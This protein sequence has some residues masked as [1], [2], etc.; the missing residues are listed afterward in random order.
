MLGKLSPV[1]GRSVMG[2]EH[3]RAHPGFG[4]LAGGFAVVEP[5][6]HDVGGGVDVRVD[7][8]DEQFAGLVGAVHEAIVGGISRRLRPP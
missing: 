3:D 5:P 7:G 4:R 6:G 1:A 2:L 8:A